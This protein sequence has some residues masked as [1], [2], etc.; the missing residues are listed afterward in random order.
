MQMNV[1]KE[2]A[3]LQRMTVKELR[4]KYAEAFGEDGG[5]AV[6]TGPPARCRVGQ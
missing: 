4:A 2:V 6:R 5:R 3:A 1:A